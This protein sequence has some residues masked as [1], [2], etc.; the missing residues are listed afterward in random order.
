MG[1]MQYTIFC[2]YK[3]C[4]IEEPSTL[5]ICVQVYP[6]DRSLELELLG[7]KLYA[8]VSLM[9]IAKMPSIGIPMYIFTNCL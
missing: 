6:Q 2:Y 1:T 3:T 7:Q 8:F 5:H 9:N 4:C